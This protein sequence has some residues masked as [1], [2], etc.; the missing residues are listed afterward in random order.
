M[1]ERVFRLGDRPVNALMTPRPDIVWL[2]LEDSAEENRQKMMES[3]HSRFPVCQ[4]GLDNVLG[5]LHVTDLL[6]RSLSGQPLDLTVSLRQPVFVPESTRGLKVLEL[7]KQTGTHMALVVD[8]YGVIQGLVTLND[9]LEEIVGDMPSIEQ[10]E[11]PQ[12]V[13]R[14]DGSWLL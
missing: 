1:L 13:Q 10:P 5:V 14:E 2:D 3:A 7:F 9:M 8:E 6:G 12:V 11:D 4:G